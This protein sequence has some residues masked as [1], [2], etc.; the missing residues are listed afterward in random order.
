MNSAYFSASKHALKPF[1]L[2]M[3]KHT[4]GS[5]AKVT[6]KIL[7]RTVA[8]LYTYFYL[9]EHDLVFEKVATSGE[10][11]SCVLHPDTIMVK[12]DEHYWLGFRN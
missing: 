9:V 11:L 10:S 12:F 1:G 4:A 2:N 7:L 6:S 8:C 3:K 5:R